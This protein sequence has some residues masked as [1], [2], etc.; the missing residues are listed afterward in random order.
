MR[1]VFAGLVLCLATTAQAQ[2]YPAHAGKV[3]D[4]A[5]VLA[6]AE[7]DDLERRLAD[8][9]RT[10]S[11]EVA[12]VTLPTLNGRSLEEYATGLFN[13][14]GIG[15]QDRDNG[16]LVLVAVEDRAMRI[17]VGYGLEGVLPDG[18]A[19][20]IIR[21]TF[22]PKFRDGDFRG[23]LL[24]G[25]ARVIEIV[26]RNETLTAA[27]LAAL[28]A[29]ARDAGKSWGFAAFLAL[30]V[31]IGAFSGGT[32]AGSRVIVQLLFGLCFTA[33]A[34]FLA[35]EVAPR[36]RGAAG[37][38]PSRWQSRATCSGAGP[39]KR[40]LRGPGRGGLDRQWQRRRVR[41]VV[42]RVEQFR[43]QLRRRQFRRRR[44]ERTLVAGRG[45][46]CGGAA[47]SAPL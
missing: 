43:Q 38:P 33:G 27:Q 47:F 37:R 30:V 1:A 17:E 14:W 24:D 26:R 36:R 39:P 9:E 35:R 21:E 13:A 15:K 6:P 22:L 42:L 28:D 34:L 31:G 29:A 4:F 16:V 11:A 12:V 44:R 10:T 41:L 20:A 46:G 23:G 8:L 19:G 3:N 25:T 7:R 40:S 2:E 45:Y 18:L 5:P 32:A